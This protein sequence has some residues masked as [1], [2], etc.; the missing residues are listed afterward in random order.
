MIA[1]PITA[2]AYEAV[3]ATPL[4]QA[5][6]APPPGADGLIRIWLDRNFVGRLAQTREAGEL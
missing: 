5:M 3:M 4:G 6:V 1:I 2:E